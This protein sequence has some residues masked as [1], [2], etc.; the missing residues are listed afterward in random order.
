MDVSQRHVLWRILDFL[1]GGLFIYAGVIKMLDPIRFGIDIDNFKMLPWPIAIRL[2]FFLPWLEILA[3]VALITRRLYLGGL[4]ILTALMFVFIGAT[5]TAKARG[6][7]ITCGCF[8]HA[9]K[10][11]S[12][13]WHMVL[14]LV[15]AASLLLLWRSSPQRF[16]GEAGGARA[17]ASQE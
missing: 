8:G 1:I 10:N 17:V 16:V 11:L 13:T 14:D 6:L 2:A 12:F 5:I 9:S 15:L 3:G 7:D 4:T